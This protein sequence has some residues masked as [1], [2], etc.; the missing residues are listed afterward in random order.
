MLRTL[1]VVQACLALAYHVRAPGGFIG[2]QIRQGAR[3]V[4]CRIDHRRSIVWFIAQ[5]HRK[6]AERQQPGNDL[7]YLSEQRGQIVGQMRRFRDR[8]E[9]MLERFAALA[10][11]D[12][13]GH[14]DAYLLVF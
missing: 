6:V 13:M 4:T 1:G 7:V 8:I 10:L 9:R 11:A 3:L 14:G 12:V 5:D 2:C